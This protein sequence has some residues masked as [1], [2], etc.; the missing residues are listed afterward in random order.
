MNAQGNSWDCLVIGG[1]I[2]GMEAALTLGDMGFRVLLVEKEAS[3]G[4]KMILLS[5]VFPTLDC[6]SCISTPKM[7]ATASH[8]N[9]TLWTYSEVK[10]VEKKGNGGGSSGF[11]VTIRRKPTY[12][13]PSKCTGCGQCEKV[14]TVARPDQFNAS[15]IARR[16][17]YIPFSQAV[18]RKAVIEK[19]GTSPCSN[20]CPAGLPAHAIVSL[21]RN[22]KT[23][24]AVKRFLDDSPFVGT[25]CLLCDGFCEMRC[26]R[27]KRDGSPVPIKSAMWHLT[28]RFEDF[29]VGSGA[30]A[31]S[32]RKIAII[33]GGLCGLT[34]AYILGQRGHSVTVFEKESKVG[35]R[36]RRKIEELKISAG[37]FEKSIEQIASLGVE[38][39]LNKNISPDEIA[40]IRQSFD[41]VLLAPGSE[42]EPQE[43][44]GKNANTSRYF[45]EEAK[46]F[47][48]GHFVKPDAT[49]AEVAGHGRAVA[50][51]IDEFLT[52]ESLKT[53]T[54]IRSFKLVKGKKTSEGLRYFFD[55]FEAQKAMSRCLDC[56]VCCDC[57]EC[58]KA[59]PANAI[60]FNMKAQDVTVSVNAVLLATG[61]RLFDPS[62]KTLLG[63][64]SYPNVITSMQ[65]DRL[66]A[67]T[68]PYNA[69]L[70]PSD[71]KLPG[72]I[73]MVL[74]TGSRD[75]TIGKASGSSQTIRGNRACSR[76]CCM[77]S[78]KQA[79]LIMGALPIAEITIYYIDIR[80]FGKG[81]EEFFEQ[82]RGMG[83]HFVKGRVAR[84]E[85][86]KN[87]DLYVYYEDMEGKGGLKRAKHDLVVLAV[88]AL[89][90][91]VKMTVL[92]NPLETRLKQD[93]IGFIKET[94]ENIEPGCTEIPG[95]F[96][97][98]TACGPKDIPD[99]VVHAGA[100]AAQV[101]A[102]LKQM[103]AV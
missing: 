20:F 1:G 18:P 80:A 100:T 13:D 47:V 63:Y 8:P 87:N 49:L 79:Q 78:I 36:I 40:E 68:R 77:Y 52:T 103:R 33:G 83:T 22:G 17:I 57:R 32:G 90:E 101:A 97:V 62:E 91:R 7:A 67:P 12:V 72:N 23:E 89:P 4:G 94:N 29:S 25:L 59:C 71:G 93:S 45:Q 99:T 88:G 30:G 102:Y 46:I 73:G 21:M 38:F 27:G 24:E 98:G 43:W 84:I 15:L 9:I 5:K 54:D 74:C 14:C 3:I 37:I 61:F 85:E 16:A 51:L 28:R 81:Y 42:K 60:D 92:G 96:V 41:A 53:S 95:V 34:A 66:L 26:T 82:A 55:D 69:V 19:S 39:L 2:G 86:A 44:L 76:I 50:R 70:R 11:N 10:S 56:G 31:R 6:S 64:S 58:E 48:A 65:M 75:I 35:G